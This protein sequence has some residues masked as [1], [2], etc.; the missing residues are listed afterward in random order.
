[1]PRVRQPRAH[2]TANASFILTCA[3]EP[4]SFASVER[5]AKPRHLTSF[6][7]GVL[8]RQ[9]WGNC[10]CDKLLVRD[11]GPEAG[12]V[13]GNGNQHSSSAVNRRFLSLRVVPA[14]TSLSTE[15]TSGYAL[16]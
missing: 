12:L 5:A 7:A 11:V 3:P 13:W 10:Q 14:F 16:S 6:R 15:A 9:R 2:H 8:I 1:M 4:V